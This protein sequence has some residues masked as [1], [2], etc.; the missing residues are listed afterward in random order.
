[1]L[2]CCVSKTLYACGGGDG[3]CVRACMCVYVH[4]YVRT[5]MFLYVNTGQC[6]SMFTGAHVSCP[7]NRRPKY[8]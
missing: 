7:S 2:L 6:M 4:T 1:M 3:V 5:A 8:L